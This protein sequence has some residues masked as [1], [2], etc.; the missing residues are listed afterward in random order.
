MKCTILSLFAFAV[1]IG[2]QPIASASTISWVDFSTYPVGAQSHT[3]ISSS[4]G[5]TLDVTFSNTTNTSADS[6]SNF[7]GSLNDPLWPF[8][9]SDLSALRIQAPAPFDAILRFDFTSSGGLPIGGSLSIIDFEHASSTAT[10]TGFLNGS[11]VPVNWAYSFY[12][13]TGVNVAP[14]IWNSSL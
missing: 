11:A 6:P 8:D 9:N 5:L 12:Q 4:D 1:L 13:I 3:G 10:F 7:V 2:T 14:P